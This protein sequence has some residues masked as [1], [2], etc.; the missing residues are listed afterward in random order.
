MPTDG[1]LEDDGVPGLDPGLLGGDEEDLGVGLAVRDVLERGDRGEP[2][3]QPALVD[4]QFQVGPDAAGADRQQE[5][6]GRQGVEQV[7][8]AVHQGDLAP[9]D[10]AIAGLLELGIAG[11]VARRRPTSPS[12]LRKMLG[13]V[14]PNVSWMNSGVI[15]RPVRAPSSTQACW[16][17]SSESTRTPSWSK[18]ASER[19]RV[20]RHGRSSSSLRTPR[21]YPGQ[22][23]ENLTRS[24]K[25]A[26]PE[27]RPAD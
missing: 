25:V 4:G 6:G 23:L 5:P 24:P 2:A 11:D 9:G 12:S 18:M 8:D 20:G 1:V 27:A 26:T 21:S 10:V 22:G 17:S 7:A 3:V 19:R 13:L 14:I 16:W 15:G